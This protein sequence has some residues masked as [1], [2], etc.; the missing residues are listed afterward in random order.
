MT[1][2]H[3]GKMMFVPHHSSRQV[4]LQNVY[5]FQHVSYNKLK[6]MMQR[7]KLK[8]LPQLEIREDTICV[9]CQYGKVQQLPY[10]E[11]KYQA[12]EPF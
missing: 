6:I 4:E 1:I 7:S 9:G 5:M 3:I 11:S 8:G 2:T 12:K 10:G